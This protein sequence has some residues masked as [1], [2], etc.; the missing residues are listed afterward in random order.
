ME[1]HVFYEQ[2][3]PLGTNLVQVETCENRESKV[4]WHIHKYSIP[5]SHTH[6]HPLESEGYGK[7]PNGLKK[8]N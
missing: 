6:T 5:D 8:K 4:H 7:N 1:V 2:I 3:P